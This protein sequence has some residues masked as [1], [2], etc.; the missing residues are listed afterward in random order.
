MIADHQR[1]RQTAH[2]AFV[3]RRSTKLRPPGVV[4]KRRAPPDLT[5]PQA[6]EARA[7]VGGVLVVVDALYQRS[8]RRRRGHPIVLE[9]RDAGGV[10]RRDGPHGDD[11]DMAEHRLERFIGLQQAVEI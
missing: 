10:A 2:D 1:E 11:G 5:R 6:F 7:L 3:E 9:E 8:R 4:P